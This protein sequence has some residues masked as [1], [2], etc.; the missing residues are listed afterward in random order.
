MS[1]AAGAQ[2]SA[3]SRAVLRLDGVA[4]IT[5]ASR[6]SPRRDKSSFMQRANRSQTPAETRRSPGTT[7]RFFEKVEC[8][9]PRP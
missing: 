6:Q 7:W 1:R 3:S 2:V 5:L 8:S 4:L 9:V